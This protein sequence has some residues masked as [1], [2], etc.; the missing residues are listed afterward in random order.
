MNIRDNLNAYISAIA[1]GFIDQPSYTTGKLKD[2]HKYVFQLKPDGD[3][4]NL[5]TFVDEHSCDPNQDV[6]LIKI[7]GRPS[8]TAT[9]Q[10]VVVVHAVS[11]QEVCFSPASKFHRFQNESAYDSRFDLAVHA[12]QINVKAGIKNYYNA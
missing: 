6:V 4:H 12:N 5:T 7:Y 11:N 1:G 2:I 10:S 9:D 8:A 3:S